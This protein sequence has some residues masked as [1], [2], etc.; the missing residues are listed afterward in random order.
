[1]DKEFTGANLLRLV[2][3]I[4]AAVGRNLAGATPLGVAVTRLCE[5]AIAADGENAVSALT[6]G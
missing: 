3:D 6:E 2:I 4:E 5:D 1:M